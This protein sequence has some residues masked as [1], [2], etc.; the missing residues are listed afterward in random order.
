MRVTHVRRLNA[1]KLADRGQQSKKNAICRDERKNR[2]GF[3]RLDD[4]VRSALTL[5]FIF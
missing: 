4:F 2:L 5:L 1:E 3:L